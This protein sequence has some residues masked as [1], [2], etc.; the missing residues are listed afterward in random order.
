ML[1]TTSD[2]SH[3][4][5]HLESYTE[6]V[7]RRTS[8]LLRKDLRSWW[9]AHSYA[10]RVRSQP[11][12]YHSMLDALFGRKVGTNKGAVLVTKEQRVIL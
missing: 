4:D 6:K 1:C 11:S 7:H 8:N 10:Y 12:F 5:R 3:V 9:E 2:T